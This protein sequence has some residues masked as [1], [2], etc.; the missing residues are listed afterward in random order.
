[1]PAGHG[2]HAI[3]PALLHVPAPHSPE[4]VALVSAKPAPKVPAGHGLHDV[5]APPKL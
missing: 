1:M 4:H 5:T 3:A 2:L